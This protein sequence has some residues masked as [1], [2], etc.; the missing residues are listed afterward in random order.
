VFRLLM[1]ALGLLAMLSGC[2]TAPPEAEVL[3][4]EM[5][6]EGVRV[7]IVVPPK[8]FRH[9]VYDRVTDAL[10]AEGVQW[11]VC[12]PESDV[13]VGIQG[14]ELAMTTTTDAGPEGYEALVFISGPGMG[15]LAENPDLIDLATS[16]AGKRKL[17]AAIRLSINVLANADLLTGRSVA[18]PNHMRA[19]LQAKGAKVTDGL[20]EVDGRI[21][22]ARGPEAADQYA[23]AIVDAL[24]A[25]RS[26]G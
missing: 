12:S 22:T 21:I 10:A 3:G 18:A 9:N 11:D 26:G 5:R 15:G 2:R 17:I 24:V 13:A 4:A 19:A 20:V 14:R 6:L 7:L 25:R 23:R 1:V 16:F 8:D